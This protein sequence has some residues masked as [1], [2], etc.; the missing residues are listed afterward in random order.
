MH[1]AP[2]QPPL[3]GRDGCQP[4]IDLF[5]ESPFAFLGLCLISKTNLFDRLLELDSKRVSESVMIRLRN[6]VVGKESARL[7][8]S[9]HDTSRPANEFYFRYIFYLLLYI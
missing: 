4:N 6:V 5:L 2:P 9:R 8:T 7:Q 1:A 3:Q